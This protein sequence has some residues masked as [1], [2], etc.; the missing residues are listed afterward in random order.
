VNQLYERAYMEK[1]RDPRSAA[2]KFRIVIDTA[3]EGSELRQK[4]QDQLKE[5]SP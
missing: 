5:L 1:D 2:E 4:A 3:E